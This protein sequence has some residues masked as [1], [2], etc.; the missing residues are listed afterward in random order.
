MLG[1]VPTHEVGYAAAAMFSYPAD[2]VALNNIANTSVGALNPVTAQLFTANGSPLDNSNYLRCRNLF[3]TFFNASDNDI[4]QLDLS[5]TNGTPASYLYFTATGFSAKRYAVI[6]DRIRNG[7]TLQL[8]VYFYPGKDPTTD[9][10]IYCQFKYSGPKPNTVH[11]I[12]IESS[13]EYRMASQNHFQDNG[14]T[15]ANYV[16]ITMYN[17]STFDQWPSAPCIAYTS[18]FLP[19]EVNANNE[20]KRLMNNVASW[21]VIPQ[22]VTNPAQ[23]TVGTGRTNFLQAYGIEEFIDENNQNQ[24]Y[25]VKGHPT[26][27]PRNHAWLLNDTAYSLDINK[28]EDVY[29]NMRGKPQ[30]RPL[31][32]NVQISNIDQFPPEESNPDLDDTTE[33]YYINGILQVPL[34]IDSKGKPQGA[35]IT[36]VDLKHSKQALEYTNSEGVDI[37][38][39]RLLF[40]AAKNDPNVVYVP[41]GMEFYFPSAAKVESGE[42]RS[43]TAIIKGY[44]HYFE[45]NGL[46]TRKL[47]ILRGG[48]DQASETNLSLDPL[49]VVQMPLSYTPDLLDFMVNGY[50]QIP[51]IDRSSYNG[52][53]KEAY[54][55]NVSNSSGTNIEFKGEEFPF[56]S[57]ARM[58]EGP[59]IT[60]YDFRDQLQSSDE[61]LRLKGCKGI[62]NFQGENVSTAGLGTATHIL[63]YTSDVLYSLFNEFVPNASQ[64]GFYPD[65]SY[66][67]GAGATGATT[68]GPLLVQ[69]MAELIRRRQGNQPLLPVRGTQV[70]PII[71][72]RWGFGEGSSSKVKLPNLVSAKLFYDVP[73][74]VGFILE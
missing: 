66:L 28:M 21:S 36:T 24:A 37:E 10:N 22:S 29:W 58:A 55:A 13:N 15:G 3:L 17:Q 27:V 20:E 40:G 18:G 69:F 25:Y 65:I 19:S 47:P 72:R 45:T 62:A 60:A 31:V 71:G 23:G 35:G 63:N 26:E 49:T 16:P 74:N 64:Y 70:V 1:E 44:Q 38:A 48:T 32:Y 33:P 51:L 7:V 41:L 59:A 52:E 6:P 46:G 50:T 42:S 2:P 4:W 73:D 39:Q 8:Q 14:Y 57:L 53:A 56:F 11:S 61:L 12:K 34:T 54:R 5:E 67:T 43:A 9:M 30:I 68:V